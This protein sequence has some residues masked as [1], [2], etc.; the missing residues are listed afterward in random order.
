MVMS[1]SGLTTSAPQMMVMSNPTTSS[2]PMMVMSGPTTSTPQMM[3]MSG[4]TMTTSA[5]QMMVMS[6]PTMQV[7]GSQQNMQ[8]LMQL[9]QTINGPMLMPMGSQ[10]IAMD[11]NTVILQQQHPTPNFI[12]QQSPQITPTPSP[13]T[14]SLSPGSAATQLSPGQKKKTR[15]RKAPTQS[16][17]TPSPIAPSPSTVPILMSPN[18]NI[19]SL[20]PIQGSQS[21]PTGGQ[22]LTI[23]QGSPGSNLIA[24]GP[25]QTV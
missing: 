4:P 23:S 25:S 17:S 11:N 24:T 10:P 9:V 1:A 22:V 6:G 14:L 15:K 8:P 12:Q 2:P 20:Q 21:S 5:P 13:V 19:M 3:V 7:A 18:G 16:P